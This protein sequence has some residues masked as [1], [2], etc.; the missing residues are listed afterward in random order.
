MDI[1]FSSPWLLCLLSLLFTHGLVELQA[2][3]I[4]YTNLQVSES[5]AQNHQPYRTAYHFQPP[6]N[7]I[8]GM[9]Y[10]CLFIYVFSFITICLFLVYINLFFFL[11]LF[12]SSEFV[13]FVSCIMSY[14]LTCWLTSEISNL[15]FLD[16]QILMVCI[17]FPF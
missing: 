10:F 12:H 4:V 17:L 2:S 1:T 11:F 16:T 14:V 9:V 6:K 8:N 13:S 15:V 3:H 5:T 7:W